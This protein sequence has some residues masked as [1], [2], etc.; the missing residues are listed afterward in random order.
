MSIFKAYDI[1]GKYPKELDEAQARAIGW[2]TAQFIKRLKKHVSLPSIKRGKGVCKIVVG[3]DVRISSPAL[4]RSL[5][6]G[7]L[8]GGAE[9]TDIGVVTT[10]MSYFAGGFYRFDGSVMVTASHNPPEYNGFKICR[11][12]AMALSETT[13]LKDIEKLAGQYASP[14]TQ[15]LPPLNSLSIVPDYIKFIRRFINTGRRPLR[16]AVD[17]TN[18]SVGPI[19]KE[20]FNRRPNLEIIPLC[21]EP[22]GRFPNHDPNPMED[23]N[24]RDLKLAIRKTKAGL[25][26][27]FDGD[28]DRVIFLDEHAQRIPNDLVT[29]LIAGEIL[30]NHKKENIVYDLR[31]SRMVQEQIARLGGRPV[32]ERVGHA[33]IKATMRQHN[34]A[35]GGELSGH[36]YYRDN[37]FADS[38]LLTFVHL[39]NLISG[40]SK[41]VSK[42]IKPLRKYFHSGELNFTVA[43]KSEKMAEAVQRF[44]DGK[45]DYL[46]GVTV[47]Y[48]DWWFNLRPSNTEPLLRLNIEA[49]TAR[50]LTSARRAIE[51][52][53]KR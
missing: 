9:V 10:P 51:K 4:S 49:D 52:I 28:G 50:K 16:I 29:I 5:I 53:L 32:R 46:D 31:S 26:V 36:Y 17:F 6:Q 7:L 15:T 23:E 22:D 2:A 39:I 38:A 24:I 45:I 8:A 19:F 13:G 41:P 12:Q 3:R 37:Y 34:A 43:D 35:F 25:G 18:G 1:R 33:F 40:N 30:K 42:I 44:S 48:D 47:E 27:A 21:F 14:K 11:E 20:I